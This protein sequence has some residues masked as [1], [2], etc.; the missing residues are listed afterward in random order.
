[1]KWVTDAGTYELG[2]RTTP[3]FTDTATETEWYQYASWILVD[4]LDGDSDYYSIQSVYDS[5]YYIQWNQSDE[6][7]SIVEYYKIIVSTNFQFTDASTLNPS[8]SGVII[9]CGDT[10]TYFTASDN[11][12]SA[13]TVSKDYFCS[14]A[15]NAMSVFEVYEH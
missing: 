12:N 9:E 3:N 6:V 4:S 13:G 15:T 7:V 10:G 11:T 8:W 1:M 5:D 14:S 2:S